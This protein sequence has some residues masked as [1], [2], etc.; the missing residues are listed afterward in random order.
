MAT[1]YQ[2]FSL[3]LLTT[4]L[5]VACSERVDVE[6][7]ARIDGQPATQAKVTVDREELGVTDAQGVFS[8]QIRK[9]A[10]AEIEVTVSKEMPGYRIDPWKT[11]F[12]VKLPKEGQTDKYRVEADLKAMRYVTLRVSEKG[13]PLSAAKVTVGG[14]EAGLTDAK[15]ELVYLYQ[16]QPAR[17]AELTSPRPATAPIARYVNS[18]RARSSKSRSTARRWWR[19]RR[20]PTS[21]AARAVCRA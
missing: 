19:S 6:V 4:A 5:L 16:A 11:T 3:V 18:I 7:K 10:G 2:R 14:K 21:T 17:G 1:T 8:K 13:V 15:G 20:S 12:L 9:K